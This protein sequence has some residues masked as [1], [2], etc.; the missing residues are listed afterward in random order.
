M[1]DVISEEMMKAADLKVP[2]E[3]DCHIG[4]DW[5]EAK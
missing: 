2:L 3:T 5:Y 1:I 4:S